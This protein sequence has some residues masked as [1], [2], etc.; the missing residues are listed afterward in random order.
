VLA[1]PLTRILGHQVVDKTGLVGNY[2]FTL[3]WT[4]ENPLPPTLGAAGTPS[5]LEHAENANDAANVSLFTAIQE[6]LGLKL[7]SEKSSVDVIVID[8]ID[9]PSPN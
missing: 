2:N 7:E 8:H 3:Q 6:Q 5:S 4:P 1:D 9:P